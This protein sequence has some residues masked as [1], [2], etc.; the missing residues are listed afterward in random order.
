[1][2]NQPLH[3]MKTVKQTKKFFRFGINLKICFKNTAKPYKNQ[4]KLNYEEVCR[5]HIITTSSLD[6]CSDQA[7]FLGDGL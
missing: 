1:M 5:I 4:K 7:V 6:M 3:N 2:S